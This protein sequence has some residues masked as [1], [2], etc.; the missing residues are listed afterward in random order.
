[1]EQKWNH[2]HQQ[3][4]H[5]SLDWES[6]PKNERPFHGIVVDICRKFARCHREKSR[7]PYLE[8]LDT[9]QCVDVVF[10]RFLNSYCT[11][12]WDRSCWYDYK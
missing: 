7:C 9:F 2:R 3:R 11:C 10:G 12:Y 5:A 4:Q 8:G 1:M 6:E